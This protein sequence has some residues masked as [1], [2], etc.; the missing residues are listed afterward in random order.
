[1]RSL[2]IPG[3]PALWSAGAD[4]TSVS[5]ERDWKQRIRNG[6]QELESVPH[7]VLLQFVVRA[8]KRRGH[9]FDLDNLVTPVLRAM[10]GD[11]NRNNVE[12]R[13][14][15]QAWRASVCQAPT[16]FLL[17]D[18]TED[19]LPEFWSKDASLLLNNTWEGLLPIDSREKDF[20]LA[21]WVKERIGNHIPSSDDR[22]GVRLIFGD[23]IRN[24]A[25]PEE[26]PIKPVVD[27]L[28]PIFG[29]HPGFGQDWKKLILQVER[30]SGILGSC[31]I[32]VLLLNS[33]K[34]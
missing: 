25:C 4:A 3:E 15:L 6:I 30:Q 20:G 13:K 26:K 7:T 19:R 16:P 28:Y 11:S 27:W 8:W 10:Y 32:Q 18:F 14:R 33:D 12:A 5:R 23:A 22:F 24:I 17:L 31:H 9:H 29:G 34:G 21:A 2:L 1:M